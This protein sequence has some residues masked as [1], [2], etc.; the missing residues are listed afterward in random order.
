MAEFKSRVMGT[1]GTRII[2]KMV[3]IA[4]DDTHPDQTAMLKF[5]GSR[6]L[7]E[8]AFGGIKAGTGGMNIHFHMMGPTGGSQGEVIDVPVV[9]RNGE[10]GE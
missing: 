3:R 5:V 2:D 7:P 6:L 1:A 8:V 10:S 4:L 9:I